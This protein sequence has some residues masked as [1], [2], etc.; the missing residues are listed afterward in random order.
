MGLWPYGSAFHIH[1]G[2][3][4]SCIFLSAIS[5]RKPVQQC[6]GKTNKHLQLRIMLRSSVINDNY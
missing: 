1:Y 5:Y 6:T 2:I 3:P 4:R